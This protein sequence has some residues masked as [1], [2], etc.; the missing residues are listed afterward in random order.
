MFDTNQLQQPFSINRIHMADKSIRGF[1]D[2]QLFG[3]KDF[4][5]SLYR[6]VSEAKDGDALT[7][8]ICDYEA[9][10]ELPFDRSK[11]QVQRGT[12]F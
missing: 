1:K 9:P 8:F 5:V 7:K 6:I 12:K 11:E 3:I 4:F 2:A 10:K